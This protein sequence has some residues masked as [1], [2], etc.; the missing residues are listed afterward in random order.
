MQATLNGVDIYYEVMG[1]GAPLIAVHGGPGMSDNRGYVQWLRPL[2]D[3]YQVVSYDL[4][5]CG[6]SGDAP[7]GSYSHA[8]FVADLD[9]LRDHLGFERFALLGTSYGGFISLEYAVRHGDRLTHLILQDTAPSHHNETAA[10]E[11]ALRSGL[12]GITTEQLDRLFGG[13]VA[14]DDEF[15]S[16]FAAIQPLYRTT[17]DPERDAERLAGIVFRYKTHNFAFSRNIP[18]YDLRDRL[19]EI[20]VPTLVMV[21]RHDWITPVDQAEYLASHIPNARLRI[22]EHSGHGPMIEENEAFIACV[23]DF[24]AGVPAAAAT[25]AQG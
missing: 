11:N 13:R 18:Q 10:R 2:A 23:R 6:K 3:S 15:R 24:L 8:D 25:S 20:R 1:E 16:S 21:G 12:P 5:G 7:D 19:G 14:D 17:E 9:A 22:F 4:R